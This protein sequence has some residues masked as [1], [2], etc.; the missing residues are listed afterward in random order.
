MRHVSRTHSVALD[1]LFDRINLQTKIQ[2]KYVETKNHFAG[3]LTSESFSRDEWNH[4]LSL[5]N[6]MSFSMFSC[7]HFSD[8]L[9]D[10][11]GMQ[12]AMSKNGQDATPSEGSPVAKPK[13]MVPARARQINLV[14]RS[15]WSEK[16]SSHNFGCLVNPGNAGEGK[17]L[18]IATRKLV[19]TASMSEVGYSQV[20]RQENALIAEGNLCMEQLQKQ[21]DQRE[22][23]FTPPAQGKLCRVQLQS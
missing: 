12:S 6:I 9:S 23:F 19:Q 4:L 17:E 14:S 11:I 22:P 18:E 5:L 10:P 7:S 20:S 1:W 13:P 15:P 2:I 3:M 21:S 8:F 16:T